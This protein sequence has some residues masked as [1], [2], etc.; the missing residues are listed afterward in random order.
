VVY[1]T[2]LINKQGSADFVRWFFESKMASMRNEKFVEPVH[3]DGLNCLNLFWSF[4]E[5]LSFT[6]T[7]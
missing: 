1:S 3:N 7:L 4:L 6:G 5:K 2:G